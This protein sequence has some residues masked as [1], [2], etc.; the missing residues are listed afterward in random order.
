MP[1][2]MEADGVGKALAPR[3]VLLPSQRDQ[4]LLQVQ[5]RPPRPYKVHRPVFQGKK[6]LP[7]SVEHQAQEDKSRLPPSDKQHRSA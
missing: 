3:E 6:L 2:I 1:Q 7:P 4:T 5:S